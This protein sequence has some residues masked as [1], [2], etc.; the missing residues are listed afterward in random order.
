[1]HIII[2]V[3]ITE[4]PIPRYNIPSFFSIPE[5][6]TLATQILLPPSNNP[7]VP[8]LAISFLSA[9]SFPLALPPT[10]AQGFGWPKWGLGIE[11]V[12]SKVGKWL[13]DQLGDEAANSSDQ[14]GSGGPRI[15]GWTLLDYYADP[16]P[17]LV[18]LLVECNFRGRKAGE[19]GW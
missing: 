15:R 17:G 18:S 1:M 7:P 14:D 8:T 6:V 12:N 19:E 9:S 3:P 13:L 11:G 2:H 16:E 5:K 10:I 4:H